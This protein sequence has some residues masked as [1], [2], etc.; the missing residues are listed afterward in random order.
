M[1]GTKVSRES[2]SS[3]LCGANK[4]GTCSL[5]GSQSAELAHEILRC[6]ELRH[7][8]GVNLTVECAEH[9]EGF[10]ECST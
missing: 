1:L 4:A 2:L 6:P 8:P 10:L 5:M 3:F 9:S 7:R